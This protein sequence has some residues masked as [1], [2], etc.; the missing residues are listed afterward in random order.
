MW[1]NAQASRV[2]ASTKGVNKVLI[3]EKMGLDLLGSPWNVSLRIW[4]VVHDK[5]NCTK[6]LSSHLAAMK[7]SEILQA[8]QHILRPH[9]LLFQSKALSS[10]PAGNS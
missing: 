5:E 10:L 1:K 2:S 7:K 4:F 9:V 6:Q 3:D 8:A